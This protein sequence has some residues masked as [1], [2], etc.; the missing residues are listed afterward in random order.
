MENKARQ[1]WSWDMG[2]KP[3]MFSEET[4]VGPGVTLWCSVNT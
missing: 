1:A 4:A 3:D 2:G